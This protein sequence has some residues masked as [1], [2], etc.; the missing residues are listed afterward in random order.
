MKNE[1]YF[2]IKKAFEMVL[3]AKSVATSS[4][5]QIATNLYHTSKLITFNTSNAIF[6]ITNTM[7]FQL[8][9]NAKATTSNQP[10]LA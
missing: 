4:A 9:P 1:F 5:V 3:N 8:V 10:I 7:P 6:V 2:S